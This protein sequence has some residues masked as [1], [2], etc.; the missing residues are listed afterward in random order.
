MKNSKFLLPLFVVAIAF[1]SCK[2]EVSVLEDSTFLDVQEKNMGVVAKRTATWCEP[3][4]GWGF[5]N[6]ESLKDQFKDEAVYMAFKTALTSVSPQGNEYYDRVTTLFG[7]PNATPTFFY[8]FDTISGQG[9]VFDHINSEVIANANYEFTLTDDQINVK[10]TTKFFQSVDGDYVISPFLILDNQ[11]GVQLGHP[12][13]PNT[14]HPSFVANL[15]HPVQIQN[16]ESWAYK[17]ASGKIDKGY[18]INL[19][20]EVAKK[21]EWTKEDI[22][23]ALVLFKRVGNKYQFINAFTK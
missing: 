12:D 21:P 7:L 14:V 18:Q 8:N 10:T 15:A 5:S 22:S 19:E 4:G 3:C 16:K 11:E 6:F 1:S 17:V 13:T 20:F 2:K 23:F 9:N